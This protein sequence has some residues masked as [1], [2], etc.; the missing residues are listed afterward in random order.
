M[1]LDREVRV[2]LVVSI[3]HYET[4]AASGLPLEVFHRSCSL[5]LRKLPVFEPELLDLDKRIQAIVA[6]ESGKFLLASHRVYHY[7]KRRYG[8]NLESIMQQNAQYLELGFQ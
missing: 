8:L 7:F 1:S 4:V 6:P 2:V 5:P 3:I